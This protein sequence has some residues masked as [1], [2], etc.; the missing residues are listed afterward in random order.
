MNHNM[1][2]DTNYNGTSY[3]T[4]DTGCDGTVIMT[5]DTDYDEIYYA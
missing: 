3:M 2:K 1:T 4:M 5:K